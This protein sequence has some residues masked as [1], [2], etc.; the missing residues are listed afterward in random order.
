MAEEKVVV[1]TSLCRQRA[2]VGCTAVLARYLTGKP[3]TL[4]KFAAEGLEVPAL[5]DDVLVMSMSSI[6]VAFPI[7]GSMY[8]D[9][10][11]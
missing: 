11:Q 4:V 10:V 1:V 8:R 2:L 5:L 6:R 3:R 9:E 7:I